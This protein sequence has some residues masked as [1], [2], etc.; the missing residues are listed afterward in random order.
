MGKSAEYMTVK[1][2]AEVWK[3]RAERVIYTCECGGIDGAAKLSG[4]WIIPAGIPEP[5]IMQIPSHS[6]EL[7]AE[8][9]KRTKKQQAF[10]VTLNIW[11]IKKRC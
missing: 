3:V 1:E 6:N 2:A 8:Q 5:I 10:I 7:P 11:R 4:Q 9:N